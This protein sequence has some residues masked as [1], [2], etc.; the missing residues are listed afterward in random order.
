MR[1]SGNNPSD[2]VLTAHTMA[3][4]S[5]L[6]RNWDSSFSVRALRGYEEC[7]SRNVELAIAQVSNFG[8]DQKS[9]AI[10]EIVSWFAFDV[11]GELGFNKS[12]GNL[13]E[14]KTVEAIKVRIRSGFEEKSTKDDQE[15]TLKKK[16][17][18][19]LRLLKNWL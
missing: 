5:R 10:D 12:F 11:M 8:K 4:H 9:V 15:G 14:G 7:L 2:S 6:R 18:F 17:S 3:E 1:S 16:S 19:W 13:K